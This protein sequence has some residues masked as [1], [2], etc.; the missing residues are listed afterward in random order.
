MAHEDGLTLTFVLPSPT[1]TAP[2]THAYAGLSRLRPPQSVNPAP[3]SA[4][5]P[6]AVARRA[7]RTAGRHRQRHTDP[8]PCWRRLLPVVDRLRGCYSATVV[9]KHDRAAV[10]PTRWCCHVA[11]RAWPPRR[12]AAGRRGRR[13]GLDGGA[14]EERSPPGKRSSD[15]N[16]GTLRSPGTDGQK[17]ERAFHRQGSVNP[18]ATRGGRW[19]RGSNPPPTPAAATA[20]TSK[21]AAAATSGAA[22]PPVKCTPRMDLFVRNDSLPGLESR[23]RVPCQEVSPPPA[24]L[25]NTSSCSF[26]SVSSS[27]L[28]NPP[29]SYHDP[30]PKRHCPAHGMPPPPP[31]SSEEW[32]G[33]AK[34]GASVGASVATAAVTV[35]A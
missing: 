6:S 29:S 31:P 35:S 20:A 5:P 27:A 7:S 22:A 9:A 34:R 11:S 21:E 17:S 26:F 24:A 2:S 19:A 18:A 30:F 13:H 1:A 16:R 33:L 15:A 14:G 28:S 23:R 32:R 4:V 12:C 25:P 10:P 3:A 8:R